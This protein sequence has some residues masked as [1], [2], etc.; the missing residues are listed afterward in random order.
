MVYTKQHS[1]ATYYLVK[2]PQLIK[3][4]GLNGRFHTEWQAMLSI[5]PTQPLKTQ[6]VRDLTHEYICD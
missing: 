6:Q 4:G 1:T 2:Y 5:Q 3:R